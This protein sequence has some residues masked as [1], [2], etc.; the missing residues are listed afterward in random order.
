MEKIWEFIKKSVVYISVIFYL[1]YLTNLK[2]RY[3]TKFP[4]NKFDGIPY[5]I[6]LISILTLLIV[7]F[8]IFIILFIREYK[9]D[10]KI[11]IFN[12]PAWAWISPKKI[13]YR[14][15]EDYILFFYAIFITATLFSIAI[16]ATWYFLDSSSNGC[17]DT[18]NNPLNLIHSEGIIISSVIIV[19]SVY[20]FLN[21]LILKNKELKIE[22][23]EQLFD[24]LNG[25]L[26]D[27]NKNWKNISSKF[28]YIF[29]FTAATGHYSDKK[30]FTE[31]AF[32][33]RHFLIRENVTFK[34]IIYTKDKIL[35][36]FRDLI[37][38]EDDYK[39]KVKQLNDKKDQIDSDTNLLAADKQVKINEI[40]QKLNEINQKIE[41]DI[42][43]TIV[44]ANDVFISYL[45]A[46]NTVRKIS[47]FNTPPDTIQKSNKI[48]YRYYRT[49]GSY[50]PLP[51]NDI[52]NYF[53]GNVDNLN[54]L[55]NPSLDTDHCL[56]NNLNHSKDRDD[57]FVIFSNE[58]GLTRFIVTNLFV[59]QFIA[60]YKKGEKIN[61]PA[62]YVSEDLSMIERY[63][64]AFEVY[65]DNP[66]VT[67]S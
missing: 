34:S 47:L 16:P 10:S 3:L 42:N 20:T 19:F 60:D 32:Y 31:Y 38:K 36:Y 41:S 25:K 23:L 11:R 62:G 67:N 7:Y 48:K 4:G 33:L 1:I 57:N 26:S 63:K 22:T 51:N 6:E 55:T 21:T 45:N 29:D 40:D 53:K 49:T 27:S 61:K 64:N 24:Y 15:S 13:R 50:T 37:K 30:R 2:W 8:F 17:S 43:E 12:N 18:N 59:V 14:Y 5:T 65:I 35:E 56:T 52:C 28:Y 66:S 44:T 58:I 9:I 54:D 39:S 46:I